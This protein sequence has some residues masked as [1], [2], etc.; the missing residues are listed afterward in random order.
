MDIAITHK[1][2]VRSNERE[3]AKQH[4][5]SANIIRDDKDEV[6]FKNNFLYFFFSL[7]AIHSLF[8]FGFK[9]SDHG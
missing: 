4:K 1:A 9:W 5:N 8:L 2:A 6:V 7:F 3:T